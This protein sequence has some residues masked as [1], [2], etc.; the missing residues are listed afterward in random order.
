MRTPPY[1]H[2]ALHKRG[3]FAQVVSRSNESEPVEIELQIAHR[4][5]GNSNVDSCYVRVNSSRGA[6]T[7]NGSEESLRFKPRCYGRPCY[8]LCFKMVWARR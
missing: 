5:I 2:A 1:T 7:G 4:L 3:G 8:F 6:K